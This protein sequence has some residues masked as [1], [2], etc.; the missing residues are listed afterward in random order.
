MKKFLLCMSLV[1]Y[2]FAANA[3]TIIVIDD[4]GVVKQQF[5]TASNIGTSTTFPT[6][7]TISVISES[8]RIQNSYYYD[9]YSTDTA[10]VA[11]LTTAVVGALLFDGIHI[12]HKHQPRKHH[13]PSVIKHNPGLKHR[14]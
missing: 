10:I 2:T 7:Q 12:H 13:A 3:E 1:C 6:T 4:N 11:G 5:S 14:R 8:P 9:K